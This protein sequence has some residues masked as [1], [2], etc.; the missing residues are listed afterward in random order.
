MVVSGILLPMFSRGDSGDDEEDD[1]NG[2][3][4]KKNKVIT[5]RR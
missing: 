3:K 5:Y 1:G 2:K 4:K